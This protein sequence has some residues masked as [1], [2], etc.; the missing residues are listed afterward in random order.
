VA[1]IEAGDVAYGSLEGVLFDVPFGSRT[2]SDD[3]ELS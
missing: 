3:V 1:D 2:T